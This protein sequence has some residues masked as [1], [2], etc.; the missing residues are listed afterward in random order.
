VKQML[1]RFMGFHLAGM[2]GRLRRFRHGR[3][4]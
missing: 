3:L 2:L 4:R 1:H